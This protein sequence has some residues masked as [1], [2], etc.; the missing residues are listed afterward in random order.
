[1]GKEQYQPTAEEIKKAEEMMTETE[2]F[3]S[4]EREIYPNRT[5]NPEVVSVFEKIFGEDSLEINPGGEIII[6]REWSSSGLGNVLI[7]YHDWN[8]ELTMWLGTSLGSEDEPTE[9]EE[10]I[11]NIR[12][13]LGI[14]TQLTSMG[15]NAKLHLDQ[16]VYEYIFEK[17]IDVKNLKRELEE[18]TDYIEIF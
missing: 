4:K 18:L 14:K 8:K 16:D 5:P 15:Y 3:K 2:K 6:N 17:E 10:L 13:M 11:K 12:R 1:M 7:E 9:P